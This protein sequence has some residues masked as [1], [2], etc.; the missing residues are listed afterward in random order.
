MSAAPVKLP[1]AYVIRDDFNFYVKCG[2]DVMCEVNLRH[3]A[4][5]NLIRDCL[6][7]HHPL[8]ALARKLVNASQNLLDALTLMRH[9]SDWL[10]GEKVRILEVCKQNQAALITE[11]RV[12]TKEGQ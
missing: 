7:Q 5:A 1:V 3:E 12:L 2:D 9:P 4:K 8:L 10:P 6:N 11:A